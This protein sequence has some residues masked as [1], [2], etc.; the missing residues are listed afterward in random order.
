MAEYTDCVER[1]PVIPTYSKVAPTVDENCVSCGQNSIFELPE[2]SASGKPTIVTGV[3]PIEVDDLTDSLAYKFQTRYSPIVQL[4]VAL[5]LLD[6]LD[7]PFP[8]ITLF[9]TSYDEVRVSW[10]Y[11]RVGDVQAQSLTNDGG[12]S[13]P[14]L[15]PLDVSH[16][17]QGLNLED[18][19]KFTIAGDDQQG[20]PTSTASDN[21]SIVFGNY[22]VWGE[23]LRKDLGSTTATEMITFIESLISG[24]GKELTTTRKKNPLTGEGNTVDDYFYYAYPAAWGFATFFQ[25]NNPGGFKRLANVGGTMVVASLDSLEAGELSL[26]V[27]NGLGS[28]AFYVYQTTNGFAVGAEFDVR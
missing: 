12:L 15:A 20:L 5:T 6:K 1:N 8:A 10:L 21:E 28:E 25:N 14:T 16:V 7:A 4:S 9:G 22:R 27:S 2:G 13:P 11:N 24:S 19:I 26:S 23:G 17:Y 3:S 18:T